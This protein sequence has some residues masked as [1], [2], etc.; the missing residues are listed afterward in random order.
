MERHEDNNIIQLKKVKSNKKSIV[1][2]FLFDKFKYVPPSLTSKCLNDSYILIDA[3]TKPTEYI[4][5][6]YSFN[7]IRELVFFSYMSNIY[8]FEPTNLRD[9]KNIERVINDALR[10]IDICDGNFKV[11][12]DETCKES[13]IIEFI[14][15]FE[16]ITSLDCASGVYVNS[17]SLNKYIDFLKVNKYEDINEQIMSIIEHG[18]KCEDY[19]LLFDN[20]DDKNIAIF[21]KIANKENYGAIIK[22]VL[23]YY[24]KKMYDEMC[25]Y[26]DI[27]L[28]LRKPYVN[29]KLSINNIDY[30][31]YYVKY[32]AGK[33]DDENTYMTNL[34]A[35]HG[36][37][38]EPIAKEDKCLKLAVKL[39]RENEILKN[40]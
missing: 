1:K 10:I 7:D 30:L 5:Y 22:L 33:E 11:I 16:Y 18:I 14:N 27:G 25:E 9:K 37:Y 15:N 20:C 39:Y 26:I 38:N 19:S 6:H 28:H 17:Y 24:N 12:G 2:Q 13:L 32:L 34:E 8:R 31:S 36:Y 4:C 23:Y 35:T 29:F 3:M 40:K 21:R